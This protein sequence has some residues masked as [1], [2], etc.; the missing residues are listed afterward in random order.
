MPRG[1]HRKQGKN[2]RRQGKEFMD[3][4]LD[5]YIRHL[6]LHKWREV[7]DAQ[8]T[9]GLDALQAVREAGVFHERGPYHDI[10]ARWWQDSVLSAVITASPTLF[11]CIEAAMRGA[12]EEEGAARQQRG[13]VVL[14]DTLSYKAFVD[15]ALER[16]F[17]EEAGAIE[18]L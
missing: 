3:A 7:A 12:L 17:A 8:A 9:L 14:E 15:Q 13:D 2:G 5:A 4:A 18:A 11:E 1:R 10:W 6:A 16:L